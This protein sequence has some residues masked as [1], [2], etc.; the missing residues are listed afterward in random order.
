MWLHGEDVMR[1][2]LWLMSGSL[3]WMLCIV[4]EHLDVTNHQSDPDRPIF[5]VRI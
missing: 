5:C 1:Y 2:A 3:G 4:A